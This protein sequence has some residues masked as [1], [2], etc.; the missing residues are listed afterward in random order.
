ML[1]LLVVRLLQ[2]PVDPCKA[3]AAAAAA[4]SAEVD[5]V[6]AA[7]AAPADP[8]LLPLGRCSHRMRKCHLPFH[9]HNWCNAM[10]VQTSLCKLCTCE[11]E[12]RAGRKYDTMGMVVPSRLV[13]G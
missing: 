2:R 8:A 3:S 11:V 1:L 12:V 6:A 5:A 9:C 4:A 7:P 13:L 10:L